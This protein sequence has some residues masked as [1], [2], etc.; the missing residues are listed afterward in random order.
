MDLRIRDLLFFN[1]FLCLTF[2]FFIIT[3]FLLF[4]KGLISEQLL[5]AFLVFFIEILTLESFPISNQFAPFL[6]AIY[7]NVH[8]LKHLFLLLQIALDH[9]ILLAGHY[10]AHFLEVVPIRSQALR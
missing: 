4:Q 7:F 10:G 3:D 1:Q 2:I 8:L 9:F 5:I 6:Q